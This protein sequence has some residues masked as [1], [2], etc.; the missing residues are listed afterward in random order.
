MVLAGCGDDGASRE[1]FAR[2]ADA[3]CGPALERLRAIE[4]RIDAVAAGADPDAIFARSAELL[5]D[6]A[7]ISREAFDRIEALE[8]PGSERDAVDAWLAASRRRAA[9]T[10]A[11]A[12]AF[13][14]QD[15]TR[16]A[17]LSEEVD[18]LEERNN[19]TA[20]GFGMRSC[21]TRVRG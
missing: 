3:I 7:A 18:A 1:E 17:R 2:Q 5:R 13:A 21:A 19:A 4:E 15:E 10:A 12:D 6:R 14:I 9:L 11:L 20:R 8:E 16:I